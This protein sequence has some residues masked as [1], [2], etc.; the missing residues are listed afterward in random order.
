MLEKIAEEC[1]GREKKPL[2]KTFINASRNV[3]RCYRILAG[4]RETFE[5][6]NRER[7]RM[8][9]KEQFVAKGNE[10]DHPT[11]KHETRNGSANLDRTETNS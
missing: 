8:R 11:N 6:V 4:E 10:E 7:F 9:R 5:I 2:I 1:M 3:N